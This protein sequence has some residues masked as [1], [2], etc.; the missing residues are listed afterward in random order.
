MPDRRNTIGAGD[1]AARRRASTGAKAW[2]QQPN[3]RPS[4][5][6]QAPATPA[7]PRRSAVIARGHDAKTPRD[8]RAHNEP[9]GARWR[10]LRRVREGFVLFFLAPIARGPERRGASRRTE[11]ARPP[12][13]CPARKH[14]LAGGLQVALRHAAWVYSLIRPFR[15]GFR[16]IG[17]VSRSVTVGR[18]A[19]RPASWV[20]GRSSAARGELE[21]SRHM[22][23][24]ARLCERFDGP[25]QPPDAI[26]SRLRSADDLGSFLVFAVR[27]VGRAGAAGRCGRWPDRDGR[28]HLRVMTNR[29]VLSSDHRS[30]HPWRH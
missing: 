28:R 29:P 5:T 3:V 13:S 2:R 22:P 15:T 11:L 17:S 10:V 4:L 14:D 1:T 24:S 27:A 21:S 16:W 18:G 25:G 20:T 9:S 19:S 30:R 7:E 23:G 12:R 8:V 26:R 6:A